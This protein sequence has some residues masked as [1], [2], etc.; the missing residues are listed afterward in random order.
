MTSPPLI[1]VENL[2]I[3][4]ADR[5][6]RV[7]AQCGGVVES[8]AEGGEDSAAKGRCDSHVRFSLASSSEKTVWQ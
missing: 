8:V 2:R 4:L 3:D 5:S 6:G 7:A 1:E